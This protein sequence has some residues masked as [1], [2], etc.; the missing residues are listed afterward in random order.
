MK[1]KPRTQGPQDL[2]A[3]SLAHPQNADLRQLADQIRLHQAQIDAANAS[4]AAQSKLATAWA[5]LMHIFADP[6]AREQ[7]PAGCARLAIAFSNAGDADCAK[8]DAEIA[9]ST[10]AMR[11]LQQMLDAAKRERGIA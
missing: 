8:A 10:A 1:M 2:P 5:G 7:L 4:R 3:N 9:A 6:D 11:S